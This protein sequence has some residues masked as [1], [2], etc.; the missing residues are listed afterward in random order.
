MSDDQRIPLTE[1]DDVHKNIALQAMAK[2]IAWMVAVYAADHGLPWQAAFA[3]LQRRAE[4]EGHPVV[5]AYMDI[6]R[7]NAQT[8]YPTERN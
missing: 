8:T 5:Q 2:V 4:S 1:L 3:A 6:C 7:A